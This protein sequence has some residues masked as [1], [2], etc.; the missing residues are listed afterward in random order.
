MWGILTPFKERKVLKE[1]S[2]QLRFAA[3]PAQIVHLSLDVREDLR[4]RETERIEHLLVIYGGPSR[5]IRINAKFER[6]KW[7]LCE[8]YVVGY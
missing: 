6:K 7:R 4:P 3:F 2:I 5:R 1:N 8:R